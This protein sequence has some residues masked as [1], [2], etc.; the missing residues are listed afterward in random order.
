MLVRIFKVLKWSFRHCCWRQVDLLRRKGY[1][2]T[3]QSQLKTQYTLMHVKQHLRLAR[4]A[5]LDASIEVY[6]AFCWVYWQKIILFLILHIIF[7]FLLVS[8]SV[9]PVMPVYLPSNVP[10]PC[11]WGLWLL[12]VRSWYG[13]VSTRLLPV[14]YSCTRIRVQCSALAIMQDPCFNCRLCQAVSSLSVFLLPQTQVFSL[15][16]MY[17]SSV[18]QLKLLI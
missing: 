9:Q 10:Y 16:S 3:L 13:T 15:K 14:I 8:F 5:I 17:W 1:N 7:I 18:V 4:K 12:T 6:M 11:R 2:F